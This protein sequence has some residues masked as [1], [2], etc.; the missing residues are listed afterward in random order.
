MIKRKHVT[1]LWRVIA[2]RPGF[3]FLNELMFDCSLRGLGILNYCDSRASGEDHFVRTLLPKYIGSKS[4]FFIDVG[5][6]I[7]GYT[8]ALLEIYPAAR[9]VAVEAN[10]KTAEK[11]K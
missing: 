8:S 1:D 2:A 7:G 10:P 3:R 6:N 11:L 5:A 9:I 4:P